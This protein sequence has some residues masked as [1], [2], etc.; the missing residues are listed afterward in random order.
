VSL[1]IVADTGE[2]VAAAAGASFVSCDVSDKDSVDSAVSA[3][4]DHLDG[5]DVFIHAAGIA[6]GAPA[7]HTDLATWE[8]V[9]AVNATGTF[10]TNQAAFDRLKENGGQ[11]INFAS[12]AGIQGLPGKAAYSASK[13]AVVAWM[14]A[15]A[16]EWG[17]YGVTVNSVAPA[18]WTPMYD[19]TRASMAPDQLREHDAMM[20]K[21]VPLG[22]KL[23]DVNK[24]FV[25]VLTFLAGEGARFMTGQVI[26][27]DG[28]TLMLR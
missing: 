14:R 15:V 25:P 1:D 2:P 6:P 16:V 26:A 9:M 23:G 3:A 28:G 12:A 18:I 21:M 24:D 27:I 4:V 8:R 10:L 5:L 17:R 19:R 11:I 22:G 20:A 7:E 13:G